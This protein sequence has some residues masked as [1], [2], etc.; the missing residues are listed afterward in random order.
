MKLIIVESPTKEKTLS[1]FLGKGYQIVSSMG[2]IR[3]LPKKKLAI[4]VE[5]DFKPQY[6]LVPQKKEAIKKIKE[7]AKKAKEIFLATDPDRE[8]EAIAWHITHL[9]KK[10]KDGF[11]R[12]VFHEI[13]Q[14][15]IEK[16]LA[17][18]KK[19]DMSLVDAQQAR[20]ILDRL[21]GYKL[22]PLLWRKIR[23]GLSAGRVQSVA[24]RLI[25]DREREIEK[26]IPDE[27]WEI[28]A[29]LKKHI[30]GQRQDM[31]LFEAKLIKKNGQTVKIE[32]ETQTK[33]I[34]DELKKANY[35]IY[36]VIRK[37]VKQRPSPP[38]ITSSLQ[39]NAVQRLGFSSKRTM[40]AAQRLYEKGLITYH[41]T[42]SFNLA[43]IAVDKIR[44]YI[45]STYGQEYLPPKPNFYKT[46][47]K[48]A[49]EA[50]EAIRPTDVQK[51]VAKIAEKLGR[52][53]EKLYELIW[54][55]AIACQ[56]NSAI[57]DK[58][59]IETQA[60]SAK[61]IYLF[62]TEGRIIKFDGWLTLYGK[63]EG[64]GETGLPEVEKGDDLNLFKLASK[65]KFTQAPPRY[66]EASLIKA[67]EEKGVGR[68][69]TYAPIISTIQN[70]Q[71]VEKI[72]GYFQPTPV[73]TTVSDFLV[74]YFQEIVDYDFT[75]K[76]EDDLDEIANGKRKWVPVI[77][78]FYQPFEKQLEGVAEVA[79]RVQIPT[80]VTDEKCPK[81]KQG[82]VVIRIGRF[83]KFLSCSRFP[84]CDYTAPYVL[85]VKGIKCPDC[86]GE[87][88]IR[89]TRRGKKFYGCSNWPKCKW[90]SWKK[91]K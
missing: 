48:V 33:Q 9:L 6:S 63:K 73:G 44:H 68:P 72:E 55:R 59:K 64:E 85:K 54:K 35:E 26:F 15:A 20:R 13:T 12:I 65:Q 62:L 1:R 53:E 40:Y 58:T 28:W 60:T 89:K 27:Y 5:A 49:Q 91:P 4:D 17:N 86:G 23:R 67:L 61:N 25:V 21:V 18:P 83:G 47:S 52:D 79:E 84:D 22:S 56:M 46:K 30:G 74:E 8:G 75:A 81:C 38:F 43:R 78:E 77:K 34:I 2:H 16:A 3:D 51:T 31:P 70:R 90:A 50:H 39:R 7:T 80:E 76:M 41:R 14:E 10:K 36:Q 57:W 87:V 45:N 24:V 69:S 29:K 32:N 88:V 19:I 37:E 82:K 66:S 42:D 71:Y 11:A